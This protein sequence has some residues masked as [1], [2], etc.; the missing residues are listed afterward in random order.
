MNISGLEFIFL[1]F[2][3]FSFS[4]LLLFNRRFVVN[5]FGGLDDSLLGQQ[6][7]IGINHISVKSWCAGDED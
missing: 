3:L 6:C 4:F 5:S 2:C 7:E 1:F